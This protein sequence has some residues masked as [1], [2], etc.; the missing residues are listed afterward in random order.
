MKKIQ[1]SIQTNKDSIFPYIYDAHAPFESISEQ[2]SLEMKHMACFLG[3]K[4]YPW[5]NRDEKRVGWYDEKDIYICRVSRDLP[6]YK[7]I[8]HLNKVISKI[9][10]TGYIFTNK[11]QNLENIFNSK[12]KEDVI[13]GRG[14][15]DI[16]WIECVKYFNK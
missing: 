14:I 15:R 10:E 8:F 12:N 11:I 13:L 3:W 5:I 16:L 7:Q 2:I 6:F 1:Q 9:E 4:Y